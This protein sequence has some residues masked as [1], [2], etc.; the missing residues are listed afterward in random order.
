MSGNQHGVPGLQ[1]E[2]VFTGGTKVTTS[3]GTHV[4]KA[5]KW[6]STGGC[7]AGESPL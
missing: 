5:L 7:H 1:G 2:Y 4:A 6:G 3:R